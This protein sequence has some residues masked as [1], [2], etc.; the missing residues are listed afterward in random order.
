MDIPATRPIM[1]N[2]MK[3]VS[4]SSPTNPIMD[5]PT[6]DPI[7]ISGLNISR[8]RDTQRLEE[9]TLIGH[10]I[11][12]HGYAEEGIGDICQ[13]NPTY[14]KLIIQ[15]SGVIISMPLKKSKNLVFVS[16]ATFNV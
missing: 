1:E 13:K 10:E 16:C 12:V 15:T 8:E 11:A 7:R 9:I 2:G 5:I 4:K 3:R 6:K 14:M